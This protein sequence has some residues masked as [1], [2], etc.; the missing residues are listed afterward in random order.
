MGIAN[1]TT[2][3]INGANLN[4]NVTS[5]SSNSAYNT[6]LT[7]MGSVLYD[8]NGGGINPGLQ[9]NLQDEI[10]NPATQAPKLG[11]G[12]S[13]GGEGTGESPCGCSG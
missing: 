9:N 2:Q 12:S 7:A 5:Q 1:S 6:I 8:L 10:A 13:T 4:Y 3:D 11:T